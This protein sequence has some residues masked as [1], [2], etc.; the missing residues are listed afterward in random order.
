VPVATPTSEPAATGPMEPCALTEGSGSVC[1]MSAGDYRSPGFR[2]G[3]SF[4]LA[5]T[6]NRDGDASDVIL[7][8]QGRPDYGDIVWLGII[9]GPVLVGLENSPATTIDELMTG[10]H[11]S[12]NLRI[13]SV[14]DRSFGA[15]ESRA[16]DV[17][18]KGPGSV[19]LFNH[20][21]A[22]LGYSLLE[23]VTVRIYWLDIGG[24]PVLV[25]VEAPT[26]SFEAFL[27]EQEPFLAS[28]RFGS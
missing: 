27:E 25:T 19:A 13:T 9:G 4:T 3:L 8:H 28:I 20:P 21:T 17:A 16:Y 15:H 6:W 23:G 1:V 26:P 12:K 22:D 5:T 24:A 18:N 2:G 7:L 10:L 11:E 14:G